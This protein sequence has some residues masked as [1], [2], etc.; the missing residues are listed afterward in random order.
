MK[1]GM[2]VSVGVLFAVGVGVLGGVTVLVDVGM[3]V[4]VAVGIGVS[5]GISSVSILQAARMSPH[6]DAQ[7]SFRK[8]FL[9][10]GDFFMF[11][12]LRLPSS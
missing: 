12:S 5:V 9:D 2:G 7:L 6:R 11:F 3:G 1:Q 10:R 8:S 4:S